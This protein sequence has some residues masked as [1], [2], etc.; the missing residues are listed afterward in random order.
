M[1]RNKPNNLNCAE[2]AEQIDLYA[3]G[4]C[5]S[6]QAEAVSAHLAGCPECSRSYDKALALVE[7]KALA[8]AVQR[9]FDACKVGGGDGEAKG[10]EAHAL[11]LPALSRRAPPSPVPGEGFR[12]YGP[13]T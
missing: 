4:E 1:K 9:R 6:A 3:A 5:E 13:E 11:T 7:R 10:G 2:V 8:P 12:W